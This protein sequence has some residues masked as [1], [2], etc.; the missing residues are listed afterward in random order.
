MN[1]L[2]VIVVLDY[3]NL[4]DV[5]VFVDKIDLSICWF[6]VGKEMFILFG[7][8]FVC[9]L[10]KWGFFVF[11]DFKFYDIL[12]I[13]L[14]VVKVVVEFGVWMVNV[15][16]SGGEWMMVVLCEILELYGKECLLLIGVIVLISMEFVD[17]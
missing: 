3:D 17:L 5:F 1:D 12:N 11:L 14:K 10:Y 8:D 2:K 15:Y 4:V 16:V 9:E 6:K 13:C 7:F